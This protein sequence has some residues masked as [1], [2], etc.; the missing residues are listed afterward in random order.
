M[1]WSLHDAKNRLS[2][3][4]RDAQEAPQ[5]I[6]VRGEERAVVLSAEAYRQLTRQRGESLR[7]FLR[8]GPWGVI[9]VDLDRARELPRDIDLGGDG[10]GETEV[11]GDGTHARTVPPDGP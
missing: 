7:A 11:V 3:L 4:V 6:A 10:E 9:E 2:Q 5:V 8:D 1:A